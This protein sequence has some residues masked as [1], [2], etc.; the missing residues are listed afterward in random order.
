MA[1]YAQKIKEI[2]AKQIAGAITI[3]KDNCLIV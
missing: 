1:S 3:I 2:D